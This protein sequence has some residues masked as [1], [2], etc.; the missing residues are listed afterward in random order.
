MVVSSLIQPEE[1][2]KRLRTVMAYDGIRAND[3]AKLLYGVGLYSGT[4]GEPIAGATVRRWTREGLKDPSD[5][6]IECLVEVTSGSVAYFRGETDVNF[7]F[8]GSDSP[9]TEKTKRCYHKSG[10]QWAGSSVVEHRTFNPANPS[11]LS[12]RQLLSLM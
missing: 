3:L 11:F 6:L 9:S 7:R 4:R 2:A 5:W 1:F 10:S 12:T 8:A